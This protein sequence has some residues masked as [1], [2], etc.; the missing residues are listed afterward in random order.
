MH[1]VRTVARGNSLAMTLPKN[2]GFEKGQNWLLIPSSDGRSF[3]LVPKLDNPYTQ[4]QQHVEMR[5][6]WPEADFNE[7][8]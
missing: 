1:E 3:T 2:L 4:D 5:E 7:V 6:A 8:E